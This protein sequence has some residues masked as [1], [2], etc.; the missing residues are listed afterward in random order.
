MKFAEE[1]NIDDKG[2]VFHDSKP[3]EVVVI[4]IDDIA[5]HGGSNY[6]FTAK[7]TQGDTI[8]DKRRYV[9]HFHCLYTEKEVLE[10]YIKSLKNQ[11]LLLEK[12]KTDIEARIR[13][14]Y[15]KLENIKQITKV[16]DEQ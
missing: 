15:N 10:V 6:I 16:E 8:L 14:I 3:I 7:N 4:S 5:Y 13:H 9:E 11:V 12:D 1:L 2:W